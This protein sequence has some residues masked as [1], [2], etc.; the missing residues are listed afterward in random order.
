MKNNSTTKTFSLLFFLIFSYASFSQNSLVYSIVNPSGG[1][2]LQFVKFDLTLGTQTTIKTYLS[3]ELDEYNSEATCFDNQNNHFITVGSIVSGNQKIISINTTNGNIDYS[4]TPVGIEVLSFVV[5]NGEIFALTNPI[6]GGD[7]Q[8]VKF[9]LIAG[10]QTIIKTYTSNE[11]DSYNSEVTCFDTQNNHFITIGY[12]TSG[13]PKIISINTTNGNIDYNYELINTDPFN[14]EVS[15][16]KIYSLST[17]SGGSLQFLKFDLSLSTKT[18]I[19]TY[20]SSEFVDCFSETSTYDTQNNKYITI[21]NIDA[22]VEKI[23]T[24]NSINGNIENNYPLTNI[25]VYSLEY[26]TGNNASLEE[27]DTRYVKLFPNPASEKI[28]IESNLNY[29]KVQIT[30]LVGE[31]IISEKN[32]LSEINIENLLSGYYIMKISYNNSTLIRSFIKN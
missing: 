31:V 10:T 24:I 12:F 32:N 6:G 1:G 11:L 22:G 17:I 29:N 21:G 5:S 13:N 30:N 25:N 14:L 19:K 20:L 9:D 23:L 18:V 26:K 8:F 15:N 2:D 28:I 3:S 7:L 16:G 27:L 4:Y